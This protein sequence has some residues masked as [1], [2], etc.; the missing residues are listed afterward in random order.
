[1]L[2]AEVGRLMED[3]ACA[4][5]CSLILLAAL[6]LKVGLLT[7]LVVLPPSPDEAP[8]Q[9]VRAVATHTNNTGYINFFA[10]LY[11]Y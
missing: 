10:H 1:M 11:I 5:L 3:S 4:E 9:A 7:A 2:E 8:P 6:A